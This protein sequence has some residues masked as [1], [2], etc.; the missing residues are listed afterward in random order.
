MSGR[1]K[2]NDLKRAAGDAD[3]ARERAEAEL[4]Q[5]L[6]RHGGTLADIRHRVG[7]TQA[8][9]AEELGVSQ[10]Q[11]SRIEQAE[12]PRWSSIQR[13]VDAIGGRVDLV[14]QVGDAVLVLEMKN[15][16]F[17]DDAE[18]PPAASED[19]GFT[20]SKSEAV[21]AVR[22]RKVRTAAPGKSKPSTT[23]GKAKTAT[24]GE[25][26]SRTTKKNRPTAGGGGAAAGGQVG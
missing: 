17:D 13:Y 7:L 19:T 16:L 12:D 6:D 23:R 20:T 3:A 10:A 21:E 9:V 22:M 4:A 18:P 15:T 14:V 1:R 24:S 25:F 8:Q 11:V 26:V 5:Q 2:F